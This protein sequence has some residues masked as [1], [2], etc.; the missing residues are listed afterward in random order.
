MNFT[1]ALVGAK[2]DKGPVRPAN[3]DAYWVSDT[4]TPVELGALYLVADGVGGQVHGAAAAHQAVQVISQAFYELRRQGSEIP[5]ALEQSIHQANQAIFEQAQARGAGKMGCTLVAG[6]QHENQL[7][8]AHV[9][10]ARA[11]LLQGK[12]L[13]RLTRDDTWVQKQVEAGVITAEDAEKHELRN[14]VTQALGNRPELDVHLATPQE[15][16]VDNIFLLCS[17]GLHGV[18]TNEQL[19]LLMRNNTPQDAANSLVEAAIEANTSDNVTAVV[20]NCGPA[21]SSET[22]QVASASQSQEGVSVPLWVAISLAAVVVLLIVLALVR[23]GDSGDVTVGLNGETAGVTQE[24]PTIAATAP[25]LVTSTPIPP[26]ESQAALAPAET[27]TTPPT[28]TPL[29]PTPTAILVACIIG[30]GNVF[31][32]QEQQIRSNT[33][34]HFAQWSLQSREQV[35]ILDNNAVPVVGPDSSCRINDFIKVQ[36]L[37]DPT[38]E[39]WV[40]QESVRPLGPEG[41]CPP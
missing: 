22:V 37:D 8:V 32:W 15:L 17:D 33:C 7:H 1:R 2:S 21:E 27:P 10:D 41:V 26:V 14:V 38:I 31:V 29:P 28:A 30:N 5:Q 19:Y 18:L 3:E 16:Q 24:M 36:S 12:R 11:Y 13:R 6:V 20:V 4:S 34:N 23:L 9:G 40:L 39:G 25:Q 35:L